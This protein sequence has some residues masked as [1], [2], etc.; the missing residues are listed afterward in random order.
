MDVCEFREHIYG[1]YKTHLFVLEPAWDS[2]RP[3]SFVGWNGAD[4]AIVDGAYKQDLLS[5][6][7]G[8]GSPEMKQ[9]CHHLLDTT[10]LGGRKEF[11]DPAVFWKWCGRTDAVWWRDRPCV[12]T[13]ACVPRDVPGWKR[14]VA[15]L[16][17]RPKTLRNSVMRRATKRLRRTAH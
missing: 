3:I 12:F 15:C 14:Y 4:L 11:K 5:P 7:Y 1:K 17:S 13:S 9:L 10:E 8:Y 6:V 2:F 16:H